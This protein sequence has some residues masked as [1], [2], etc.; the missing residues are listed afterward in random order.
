MSTQGS[1]PSLEDLM[2]QLAANNLEFQQSVSSSNMQFQENMTAT[3]QDL[4]TQI[5]QL[6]NTV[7]QLQ[8]AGSSNLPSQSIP[9]PRGNA[10]VVT[11]RSGK[12]LSQPSQQDKTVLVLFPTRTI[13]AKKL[14][15][16]EE[17]L[18]MFRKVKINIPLL[19]AIKQ[20][21]KY[22]KFLKELCMKGSIEIGGVVSTLTRN[23]NFTKG[24]QALPT[25]C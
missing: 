20:I 1:S 7:S 6:A 15:L 4:K 21:P 17:L 13:L 9:N 23:E 19:D 14:E 5:G 24:A 18:K 3:I 10:S 12:E 22:A 16:D 8:S 11:L 25:K 2:K